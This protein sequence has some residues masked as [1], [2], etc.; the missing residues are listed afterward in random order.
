MS[1]Y[2]SFNVGLGYCFSLLCSDFH[3]SVLAHTFQRGGVTGL[4]YAEPSSYFKPAFPS[5]WMKGPGLLVM[6]ERIAVEVGAAYLLSAKFLK[7]ALSR[8]RARSPRVVEY[9]WLFPI[10][11]A[12]QAFDILFYECPFMIS[13][14]VIKSTLTQRKKG[15]ERNYLL[16]TSKTPA[17][18]HWGKQ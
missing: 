4:R 9:K 16:Y 12:S 3:W 10:P 18:H 8:G 14:A 5:Q 17:T 13:A 7:T 11:K 15:K 1:V 2:F 6:W